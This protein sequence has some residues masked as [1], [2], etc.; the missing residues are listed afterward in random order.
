M[1]LIKKH[2]LSTTEKL[3]LLELWNAE[4]PKTLA[5]SSLESLN[6]YLT[7][8]KDT[9]HLLLID[10]SGK[11]G[12]WCFCFKREN[13]PWFAIIIDSNLKGQGFGTQLLNKLKREVQML[14]GWVIDHDTYERLNLEPYQS[15]LPFY[16]KNGFQVLSEVRLELE[17]ISAVK[18]KWEKS[19]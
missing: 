4:Y 13:E 12:S 5:H 7:N 9:Y 19:V 17:H 6:D 10:K 15:P 18:I 8:L 1:E 14:N 3:Q 11:I 2:S 16:L